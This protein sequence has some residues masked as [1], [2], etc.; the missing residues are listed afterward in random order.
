M[1][2]LYRKHRPQTFS[3]VVNQNHV[4]NTLQQEIAAGK[5]AHA[6]LFCGPRGIGKTTLAR[7]FAKAINCETLAKGKY[8]PCDSCKACLEIKE[9]RSM[10][11]IEIDAA[12]HTG[13]DNVR[14]NVIQS[15]RVA[16]SRLKYKVF[17][18]DEVHMLSPSA[19]N[20][21]LK[22]I[23]EPAGFVM[24]I[25]CTTEI[26]KVPATIISRCQRFD[27]KKIGVAEIVKKLQRIAGEEGVR[28]SVGILEEIARRSEGHMR[29]AESLLG[30]LVAIAGESSGETGKNVKE[31]TDEEASL[32]IPRSNL[33][34]TINLIG[35]LS[36]KDAGGAIRLV[37]NLA[38]EGVDLKN[39]AT[40]AVEILRKSLL[41]KVNPGLAE[42]FG[43]ELGDQLEIELRGA[44]G[45]LD[46]ERIA[47]MIEELVKARNETRNSFIT[48]LPLE[49][50][51]VRICERQGMSAPRPEAAGRRADKS[52]P[53][54][55]SESLNSYGARDNALGK[56]RP[57]NEVNKVISDAKTENKIAA[58]K[59]LDSKAGAA[60]IGARLGAE[61][62]LSKWNEV[63]AKIKKHNHSLSFILRV[64]QPRESRDGSVCLAF[65]YKFHKDR[66]DNP[67]I[68][69]I[70]EKTLKEV[71]NIPLKVGTVV[72]AAL[73]IIQGDPDA[74]VQSGGQQVKKEDANQPEGNKTKDAPEKLS[75]A[76]GG[77]I[78]SNLLK[79]FG[80]RIVG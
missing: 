32:V 42:N 43:R 66:I 64:C 53:G 9:G 25:F 70:V 48:Q 38:D 68:K 16:P 65:K 60:N 55:V 62:L 20:A 67:S 11:I 49:L 39:F 50:A 72:D 17:I 77:D 15:A 79:T 26:H 28:I 36:R 21:L 40:N 2:T 44:A 23:E 7:V 24:F 61:E 6:Y 59:S 47:F 10:D 41:S 73:E 35:F 30:Q 74:P 51:I 18:I 37:N 56:E 78:M 57:G 76:E 34:E 4:K 46:T 71:Y 33:G 3:E 69:A 12:S 22:T 52:E 5:I 27:F 80:G 31:I 13:V 75:G 8:E 58:E 14:E 54:R 63:L 45:S 19:F 29:D 1:A